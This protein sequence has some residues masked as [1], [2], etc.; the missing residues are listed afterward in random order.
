MSIKVYEILSTD[1]LAGSR[2]VIN[3]NFTML[4]DSLNALYNNITIN[5]D[6]TMSINVEDANIKNFV[7]DSGTTYMTFNDK[8]HLILLDSA[9]KLTLDVNKFIENYN[10]GSGSGSG[11]GD[12]ESES[13]KLEE[14]VEEQI[15]AG[16]VTEVDSETGETVV[17]GTVTYE[18]L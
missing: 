9:G 18:Y 15:E 5:D 13:K 1:S 11:S 7:N 4:Q 17:Q 10:S 12:S 14:E 3:D 8:G 16:D 2:L 6:S